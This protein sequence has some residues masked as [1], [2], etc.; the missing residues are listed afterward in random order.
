MNILFPLRFSLMRIGGAGIFNQ[1]L[2]RHLSNK[3]K[4][5]D[6]SLLENATYANLESTGYAYRLKRYLFTIF[7]ILNFHNILKKGKISLVHLSPSLVRWSVN[8]D[9]IYARKCIKSGVPFVTFIHGWNKIYQEHLEKKGRLNIFRSIFNKSSRVLVLSNEFKEKLVEWGFDVKKL[10]VETT[11]V[12]SSLLEGFDI[13]SK[14]NS[15]KEQI[16]ILFL[17]RIVKEKGVY[18]TIDAYSILKNKG[19][20]VKLTIAG[21]GPDLSAVKMYV[22]S[23]DIKDVEFPGYVAGKEKKAIFRN[24]DIYLFPTVHGEGMPISILEAISFGLAVITRPVG[25][26][27]DFFQNGKHG[28][29]TESISPLILASFAEKLISNA[30]LKYRIGIHNYYYSQKRFLSSQVV[31]RMENVFDQVLLEK[32]KKQNVKWE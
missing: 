18:Q 5:F 17:S 13:H 19:I 16:H 30:E 21:D 10:I 32:T 29:I 24:S 31:K 15:S 27:K 22:K 26:I 25:G 11:M 7:D 28:F 2:I 6:L 3:Y 1:L 9:I 23:K 12:D 20:S 14:L 4:V 8:R